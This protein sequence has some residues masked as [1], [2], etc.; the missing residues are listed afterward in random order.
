MDTR[1]VFATANS[2]LTMINGDHMENALGEWPQLYE[3]ATLHLFSHLRLHRRGF[4]P[5]SV[6]RDEFKILLCDSTFGFAQ[7]DCNLFHWESLSTHREELVYFFWRPTRGR[8]SWCSGHLIP[9]MSG[10]YARWQ[11]ELDTFPICD[12]FQGAL[13]IFWKLDEV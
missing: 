10:F 4:P 5:R 2:R 13:T 7:G 1:M 8:R 6:Q 12:V 3:C 9:E 11:R